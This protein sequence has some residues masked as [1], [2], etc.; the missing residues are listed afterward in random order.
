ML[1]VFILAITPLLSILSL[2]STFLPRKG[3]SLQQGVGLSPET[4]GSRPACQME[5]VQGTMQEHIDASDASGLLT[6]PSWQN[7]LV[8]ALAEHV[9]PSLLSHLGSHTRTE[10]TAARYQKSPKRAPSLGHELES[11]ELECVKNSKYDRERQE[12]LYEIKWRGYPDRENTWEPRE[13]LL[14]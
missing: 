2:F 14:P 11:F 10:K 6:S 7:R 5:T 13:N 9:R 12:V 3:P 8:E 4:K 1:R